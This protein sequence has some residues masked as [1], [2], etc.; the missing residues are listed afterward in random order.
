[1]P[2][3]IGLQH[4]LVVALGTFATVAVWK[5]FFSTGS[6]LALKMEKDDNIITT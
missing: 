3:E 2:K 5:I 6:F 4:S 1:M